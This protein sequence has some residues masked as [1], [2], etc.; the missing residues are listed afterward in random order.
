MN[1]IILVDCDGVLL[2]WESTFHSFLLRH[3]YVRKD[4]E[5][6]YTKYYISERYKVKNAGRLTRLFNESAHM[7]CLSPL[8][9]SVKYVRK[10]FEEYGYQFHVITS[11]TNLYPA[12]QLRIKNLQ[13][14]F[15]KEVFHG[16]TFLDCGGDKELVLQEW[17]R[18]GDYM[19][20]EDKMDNALRG[21]DAGLQPLLMRHS[22]H[23]ISHPH[24]PMFWSWK[25][26]YEHIT[27]L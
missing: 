18:E 3:N 2:D 26:I 22:Y 21:L 11:Q 8:R 13:N 16:F 15:G 4:T 27:H 12:Q 10:L 9:D 17:A 14:A 20:I 24:V 23:K 7:S 5:I 25:E 6:D 19:W 1:K